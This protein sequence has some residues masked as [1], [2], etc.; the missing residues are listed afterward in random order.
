MLKLK[1]ANGETLEVLDLCKV[2]ATIISSTPGGQPPKL[3]T[4]ILDGNKFTLYSKA[5]YDLLV[6]RRR[7]VFGAP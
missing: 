3:Y 5:E 4:I 7:E 2:S 1:L 6:A